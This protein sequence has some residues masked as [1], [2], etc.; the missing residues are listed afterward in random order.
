MLI[1]AQSVDQ[2]RRDMTAAL[3][4]G[5]PIVVSL[6]AQSV[7]SIAARFDL[8]MLA[9]FRK[10]V[11]FCKVRLGAARVCDAAFARDVAL[12]ESLDEFVRRKRANAVDPH[13][14]RLPL[15]ASAC[16][17]WVCYAEKA[18]GEIGRAHV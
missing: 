13:A 14:H 3:Q 8:S 12:L 10:L 1:S 11:H 17:G 9:T 7:A 6:A 5:A 16:P 18:H 4:R 2:V 15:L